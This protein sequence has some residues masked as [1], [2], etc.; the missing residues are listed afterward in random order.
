M[1]ELPNVA[2]LLNGGASPPP[3]LPVVLRSASL[4]ETP[5][6]VADAFSDDELD[7][8]FFTNLLESLR[9]GESRS[10]IAE[11]REIAGG[12]GFGVLVG[13]LGWVGAGWEFGKSFPTG[14]GRGKTIVGRLLAISCNN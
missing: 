6:G 12:V 13:V 7:D 3:Q 10:S 5:R 8:G 11:K 4:A 9:L 2:L 1:P 14:Q